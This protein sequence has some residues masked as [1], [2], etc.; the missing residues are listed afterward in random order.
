MADSKVQIKLTG[1]NDG[2]RLPALLVPT[3]RSTQQADDLFLP[4]GYLEPTRTI[5][6]GAS[7]RS[8]GEGVADQQHGLQADELVVLELAD[9]SALITSAERLRATLAQTRP[10]LLGP[11]GAVLLEKLRAQGAAPGR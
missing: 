6:V 11:D 4:A 10:E 1:R 8:A 7:A 5:D 2:T 3:A 9:G